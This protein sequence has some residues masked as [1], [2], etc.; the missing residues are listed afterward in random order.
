MEMDRE[1]LKLKAKQFQQNIDRQTQSADEATV[2]MNQLNVTIA[3]LQAQLKKN[4]EDSEAQNKTTDAAHNQDMS[5]LEGSI[6]EKNKKIQEQEN[7]INQTAIELENKIQI[8]DK[9]RKQIQEN[10]QNEKHS[11]TQL[12][13]KLTEKIQV[14]D[15]QNEKQQTEIATYKSQLSD[16]DAE[17]SLL[18]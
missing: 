12:E 6:T 15:G 9:L 3:D 5:R 10:L 8:E 13:Q 7:K 2:K 17:K 14:L 11:H 18:S 1:Q 4:Q 16:L